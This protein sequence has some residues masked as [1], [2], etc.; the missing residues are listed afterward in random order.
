M[1]LTISILSGTINVVKVVSVVV[2]MAGV[3][4]TTIGKTWTADESQS[5]ISKYVFA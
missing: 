2:S 5:S 4:M 1:N 3:A